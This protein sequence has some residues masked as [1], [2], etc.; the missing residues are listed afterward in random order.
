M[1][2]A[3]LLTAK[4]VLTVKT[5]YVQRD[6]KP[7]S[8]KPYKWSPKSIAGI[9]ERPEYTGCT[10]NFKT[11][12]KSHKLKK[13]LHNAPENQRIF[14]N[15]QPAIIEEQVF[16]R[17]QELRENKRRPAKQAERQGL[18]SGLLYC[19]DCGSKLHFATGK[20]MTPQQDCYQ[21][22]RYKSNTGDCT[23]HFIREETLKLFV[24]RRIFDVTALFFD[25]AMAFEEAARKQR[26]QEAEKEA[27]KRRRK[28]P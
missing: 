18:F 16:A 3:K 14:P 7:L 4:H 5:H 2:I 10:V 8:E 28:L 21:C 9:L 12:S 22:S 24:L 13:R 26:F 25:D 6:G 11:Y 15:T 1:Q 27:R 23:M 17:V 20:N 19:A